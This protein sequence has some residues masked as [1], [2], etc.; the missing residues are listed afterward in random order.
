MIRLV[1]ATRSALGMMT[2]PLAIP[3]ILDA[4]CTWHPL[5][6]TFG[7][8]RVDRKLIETLVA[9]HFDLR[10]AAFRGY[11]GLH[12]PIYWPGPEADSGQI[13]PPRSDRSSPPSCSKPRHRGE[14]IEPVL[15]AGS[16]SPSARRRPDGSL[17]EEKAD[18]RFTEVP[19]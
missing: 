17:Q 3:R 11:L 5:V 12:R 19:R 15:R 9:E 10:P 6:D 18:G 8:E 13:A 1:V 4:I 14:R 16:A 7:T 2:I